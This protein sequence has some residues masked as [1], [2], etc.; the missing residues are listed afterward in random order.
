MKI[1][2]NAA[3]WRQLRRQ[4]PAGKSLGFVPTMGCL[5]EGHL[6][7]VQQSLAQN[8]NTIVSIFINPHQFNQTQDF[9]HYPRQVEA[10]L[11]MLEAAGVNYCFLPAPETMY[12]DQFRYKI[13]AE[14]ETPSM[15]E[16]FRPGHFTGV[17][18]VVMKL[19]QIVQADRA[20]FGEKDFQQL[21]L[22]RGMVESFFIPTRI[23]A[24]PT[25]REASGLPF[26]SRNN[27]LTEKQRQRAEKFAKIFH[28]N[29]DPETMKHQLADAGIRIDYIEQQQDRLFAAVWIDDIRLI[30]NR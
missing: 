10:D 14:T 18:T 28:Q 24:C 20:Y 5:H 25:L 19:L 12:A 2:Q 1:I 3:D 22:I 13:I 30:D 17:L 27:R 26:S 9:L 15:E 6:S 29:N 21:E 16:A 7:L 11:Q 23:I 4:A 8:D